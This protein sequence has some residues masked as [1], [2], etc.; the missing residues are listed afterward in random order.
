MAVAGRPIGDFPRA[1]SQRGSGLVTRNF[2]DR[3][4]KPYRGGDGYRMVGSHVPPEMNR[5][6]DELSE[7]TGIRRSDIV[8]AGLDMVLEWGTMDE[9][10]GY[11]AE[12]ESRCRE[13]DG[14]PC[15]ECGGTGIEGGTT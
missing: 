7:E 2:G 14:N 11:I 1:G 10:E 3:L 5:R 13:L 15:G 8:R 6:L 4:F 9:V 12:L